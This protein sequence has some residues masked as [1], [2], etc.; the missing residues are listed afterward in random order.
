MP[1]D[2]KLHHRR[3]IRLREYDYSM[4]GVYFITVVVQD[5]ASLFGEVVDAEM[6]LN[7]AGRLIETTWSGLPD[8]LPGIELDVFTVMPNHFHGIVILQGLDG[9]DGLRV[10]PGQPQRTAPTK[11]LA[12][13]DVVGRFKS[14]TTQR[15]IEGV[16]NNGWQPF[17]QR[18]W[19]RNYFEHVVRGER[20]ADR[21]QDYIFDNP[22]N[23]AFDVENLRQ[24]TI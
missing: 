21:L 5:R 22:A 1:F 15:Y 11:S 20:D 23:W 10:E 8:F 16:K 19:Q 18:L 13:G 24:L 17:N 9:E 7:A 2:P 12:L 4:P 14:I 6:R 3:S